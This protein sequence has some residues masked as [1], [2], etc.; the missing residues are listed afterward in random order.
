MR[1]SNDPAPAFVVAAAFLIASFSM[2]SCSSSSGPEAIDPSD[3]RSTRTGGVTTTSRST[4]QVAAETH[5]VIDGRY[6]CGPA[7]GP[8]IEVTLRPDHDA[9]V[10]AELS[11]GAQVRSRSE[12]V[13]ASAARST[14]V[15]FDP[16]R[17]AGD[18]G[19][20]GTLRLR[21][22]DNRA[23]LASTTVVLANPPGVICG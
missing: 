23:V 11:V 4:T 15:G 1:T 22:A 19:R 13:L 7:D 20:R 14:R 17:R 21:E 9:A 12:T 2:T 3:Y 6:G 16:R 5:S 18:L 10:F 8:W